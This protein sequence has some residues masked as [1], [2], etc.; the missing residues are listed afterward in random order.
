MLVR[1]IDEKCGCSAVII[2]SDLGYNYGQIVFRNNTYIEFD[3]YRNNTFTSSS[4]EY[5]IRKKIA[6]TG[7]QSIMWCLPWL[8]QLT[9]SIFE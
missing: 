6:C 7:Y 4:A 2:D 5:V 1:A 3:Y 8:G 9:L